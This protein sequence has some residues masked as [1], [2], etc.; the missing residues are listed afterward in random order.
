MR[1]T[2]VRAI[3]TVDWI[4]ANMPADAAFQLVTFNTKATS[5]VSESNGDWLKAIE[6][7]TTDKHF[8]PSLAQV[9]WQCISPVAALPVRSHILDSRIE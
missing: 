8:F 3:A 5:V 2:T 6:K 4:M 7:E 9:S 1:R